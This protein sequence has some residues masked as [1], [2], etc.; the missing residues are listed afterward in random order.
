MH[1]ENFE[2]PEDS[3]ELSLGRGSSSD[4]DKMMEG[5]L[6]NLVKV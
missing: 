4:D 5:M 2:I 3:L 6:N 1:L